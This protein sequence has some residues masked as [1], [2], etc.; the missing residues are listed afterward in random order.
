[1]VQLSEHRFFSWG[2]G[3]F[4]AMVALPLVLIQVGLLVLI[5]YRCANDLCFDANRAQLCR[6]QVVECDVDSRMLVVVIVL[7]LIVPNDLVSVS[8]VE[9]FEFVFEFFSFF[10]IP[11]RERTMVRVLRYLQQQDHHWLMFVFLKSC[12]VCVEN[13]PD[14]YH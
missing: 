10:S 4:S 8:Y 9:P 1:M 14:L 2:L 11:Y 7:T 3:V 5:P 13:D 6:L 12:E